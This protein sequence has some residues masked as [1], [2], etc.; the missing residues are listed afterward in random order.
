MI[1]IP[2][3]AVP[4]SVAQVDDTYDT[5]GLDTSTFASAT[6]FHDPTAE[7]ERQE[8]ITEDAIN[9]LF[10]FEACSFELDL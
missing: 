7:V 8:R 10:N 9:E 2:Q 3:Y 1:D 5:T 6:S 4:Y